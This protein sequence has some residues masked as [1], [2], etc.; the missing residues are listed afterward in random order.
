MSVRSAA[1]RASSIIALYLFVNPA[2][3]APDQPLCLDTL[4]RMS[5]CELEA[6]YR[7]A[8]PAPCLDGYYAGRSMKHPKATGML[9]KGKLFC[10][11][12]SKL[13]NRWCLGLH[14][15]EACIYPGESWLD[16]KPSLIM[17]YRES[18]RVWKDVRDELRE[19]APGLYLGIMYR[20]KGC[21]EPKFETFFALECGCH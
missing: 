8:P 3:A 11:A 7:A 6:L 15:I 5:R 12:D 20:D 4:S 14:A 16:G 9:W 21:C 10:A 13:I 2:Q 1:I 19:V 18:S 17:D